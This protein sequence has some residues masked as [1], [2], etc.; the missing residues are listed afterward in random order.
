MAQSWRP[1]CRRIVSN[2]R[3]TGHQINVFVTA[4]GH[5]SGC[6]VSSGYVTCCR[7]AMPSMANLS[8]PEDRA[9]VQ[10]HQCELL[11]I[12]FGRV[13]DDAGRSLFNEL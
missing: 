1:R 5:A 13:L 6:T 12:M 10:H 7:R 11:T 2:L 3:Y 9:V 8:S 4:A